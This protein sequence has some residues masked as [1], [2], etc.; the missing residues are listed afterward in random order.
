MIHLRNERMVGV[1]W[2]ILTFFLHL[3]FQIGGGWR[4][5]YDDLVELKRPRSKNFYKPPTA[6]APPAPAEATTSSGVDDS[7]AAASRS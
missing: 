5:K 2:K 7:A 1:G 6:P 4:K 3:Q